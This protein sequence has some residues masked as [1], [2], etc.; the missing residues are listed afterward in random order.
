MS[1]TRQI[2]F[3]PLVGIIFLS[4]SGGAY[5]LEELV[6]ASGPGLAFLLLL[7]V[8]IFYGIPIAAITTEL[9]T[10]IPAEGGTYEWVKRSLGGFMAFQAGILRWVN[11]WLDMAIYPVLFTSYIAA[12]FPDFFGGEDAVFFRFG[13]LT[14]DIGWV[15][16]VVFVIIPM[17][18]LN[19]RG[20]RA[21]GQSAVF[22][23]VLALIPLLIITVLGIANLISGNINPFSPF[24]PEDAQ[25]GTAI[26]VGLAIVMWSYCGFDQVGLIA[27]EIQEPSKTIPKA[28]TVSMIVI[29]L[30][31]IL[32]LLGAMA[33][34][35]WEF[36]TAGSFVDIGL[37]LGGTWLGL[38]VAIGG[39]LAAL[40]TYASLLLSMSRVPFVLAR[41]SWLTTRL[42]RESKKHSSPITSIIVSSVIYAFF[43]MASF[44]DLVVVNVFLLNVLLLLNVI[45]LVILRVRQPELHRPVK[46]PF[47]WFG[48]VL[49]SAPLVALLVFLTV[50]QFSESGS[51]SLVLIGGTLALSVLAYFPAR[52]YQKRRLAKS[53]DARMESLEA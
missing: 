17:A 31:Y 22:L 52:A 47:G 35:G 43:T 30:A 50:L 24:M 8:P 15:F 25:P 5:S 13:P 9:A 40:G 4:V 28:M 49:F 33:T 36:W 41:D 45:A 18:L 10:A 34:Q 42:A 51:I 48:L 12:L 29:T 11:S 19:I 26:A 1:L 23:T 7:L 6:S 44:V 21:V 53:E 38:A 46:I 3:L 37:A 14:L 39:A 2:A 20:S 27:G 32:P 16:G